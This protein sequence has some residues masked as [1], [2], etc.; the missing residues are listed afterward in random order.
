MIPIP[1]ISGGLSTSANSSVGARA[2]EQALNS[3][4]N[5]DN[6]VFVG[7]SGKAVSSKTLGN[8]LASENK[9][10]LIIG[11]GLAVLAIVL[12]LKGR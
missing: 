4:T 6:S 1:G 2:L 5:Q 12:S 8:P 9:T 10:P 3:T 11:G 7:G